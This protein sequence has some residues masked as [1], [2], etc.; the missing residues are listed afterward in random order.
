MKL[1]EK[2]LE[3]AEDN[4]RAGGKRQDRPMERAPPGWR[5][6][7]RS[8]TSSVRAGGKRQDRLKERAPP[9]WGSSVRS[10]TISVRAGED[11]KG[12]GR[13][14]RPRERGIHRRSSGMKLV[15]SDLNTTSCKEEKYLF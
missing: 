9:G 6:S 4:I 7:V 10:I 1:H 3:P 12:S 8:I 13:G 2:N 14:A 11:I 5:S 15:S